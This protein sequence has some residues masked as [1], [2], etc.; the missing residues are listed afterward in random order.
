LVVGR[1]GRWL[2]VRKR[3]KEGKKLRERGGGAHDSVLWLVIGCL[4]RGERARAWGN[5]GDGR[6]SGMAEC[7]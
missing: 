1:I 2:G 4:G 6:R 5:G 7:W 3:E